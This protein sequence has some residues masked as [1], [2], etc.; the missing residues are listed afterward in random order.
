MTTDAQRKE[1]FDQRMAEEFGE[2][3][4]PWCGEMRDYPFLKCP[5]EKC[6]WERDINSEARK[7]LANVDL[8]LSIAGKLFGFSFC[9]MCDT[10][11]TAPTTLCR[12][13]GFRVELS[14]ED[15]KKVDEELRKAKR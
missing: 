8:K 3:D 13:C 11:H 5:N 6:K 10:A 15:V 4:C 9:P 12:G 14:A 2:F 7:F 1:S